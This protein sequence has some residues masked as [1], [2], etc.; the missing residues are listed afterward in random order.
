[1]ALD[2]TYNDRLI[3]VLKGRKLKA[4]A[5]P[6]ANQGRPMF[7][8]WGEDAGIPE[9]DIHSSQAYRIYLDYGD[10][11]IIKDAWVQ[12]DGELLSPC[13]GYAQEALDQF[14]YEPVLKWCLNKTEEG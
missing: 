7:E 8:F 13:C 10:D 2:Y 9:D 3:S 6:H 1:M 5:L 12:V 4:D 14:D 11:L